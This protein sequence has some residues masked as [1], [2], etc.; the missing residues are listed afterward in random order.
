MVMRTGTADEGAMSKLELGPIGMTLE[1]SAD[2]SH[3]DE[4]AAL[5]GLG[6]SVIWLR[7]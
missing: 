2:G 4:A 6:Y 3:L 5:E 1:L 7:G